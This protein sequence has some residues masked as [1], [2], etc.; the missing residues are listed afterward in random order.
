[1]QLQF[2]APVELFVVQLNGCSFLTRAELF[3]C[4]TVFLLC[5]IRPK[6]VDAQI[7]GP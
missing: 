3:F 5:E 4:F 7:T 2:L 6:A 1:M